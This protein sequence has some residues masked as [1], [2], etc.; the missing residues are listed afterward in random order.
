[1]KFRTLQKVACVAGGLLASACCA[2]AQTPTPLYP[3][4]VQ[5][6]F[7]A[8]YGHSYDAEIYQL[9]LVPQQIPAISSYSVM[10]WSSWTCQ[11]LF[12]PGGTNLLLGVPRQATIAVLSVGRNDVV[13][14]VSVADH[15]RC[16]G[17]MISALTTRNPNIFVMFTNVE[18]LGSAALQLYGDLR[19]QIAAYNSAYAGL[20]A[21]Y[22]NVAIIDTW[23]P[24]VDTTGVGLG[25]LFES[26]GIHPSAVGWNIWF[27]SVRNN[28]YSAIAI[29]R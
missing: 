22:S 21:R 29:G 20:P 26:T 8:F 17:Q 6:Q 3:P 27:G 13:H 24:M 4:G 9:D 25:Y 16:L 7:V 10:G 14:G 15:V 18:P 23:T 1:M 5:Q 19:P 2:A 11:M 12:G 28:L